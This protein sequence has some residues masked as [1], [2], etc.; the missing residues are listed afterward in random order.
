MHRRIRPTLTQVILASVVMTML[1]TPFA[2]AQTSSN[3][4]RVTKDDAR[5]AFIARNNSAK[6]GGAGVQNTRK[7]SEKFLRFLREFG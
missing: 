4:G 1:I 5:Y 2:V 3:S 6:T 7:H